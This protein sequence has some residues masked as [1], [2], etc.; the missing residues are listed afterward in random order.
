MILVSFVVLAS[1]NLAAY[2]CVR[3][4]VHLEKLVRMF[5]DKRT[6]IS[7]R[8]DNCLALRQLPELDRLF[9]PLPDGLISV[10]LGEGA[11]PWLR[12]KAAASKNIVYISGATGR[13]VESSLRH[14]LFGREQ[15][16][17]LQAIELL[18]RKFNLHSILPQPTTLESVGA[19]LKE[20][21]KQ[22]ARSFD[23]QLPTLILDHFDG[24]P[25]EERAAIYDFL[26]HAKD[27]K[28]L[29][30]LI[31]IEEEGQL[32][33]ELDRFTS[34]RIDTFTV[35]PSLRPI[36]VRSYLQCRLGQRP[37]KALSRSVYA[38][39]AGEIRLVQQFLTELRKAE[40]RT[41][42]ALDAIVKRQANEFAYS[43]FLLG[44]L[45]FLE[46]RMDKGEF[47]AG[48]QTMFA[49]LDD[50]AMSL[51]ELRLRLG[52]SYNPPPRL[53]QLHFNPETLQQQLKFRTKAHHLFA[54]L[55]LGAKNSLRRLQTYSRLSRLSNRQLV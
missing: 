16:L 2:L 3:R 34:S 51:A 6:V 50:G 12:Q 52:R 7:S 23:K 10:V 22:L 36:E 37:S 24:I 5:A 44:E 17:A 26:K 4:E 9:T 39:T 46:E 8:E 47:L 40:G 54:R 25:A 28:Y 43:G 35:L 13:S 29:N 48:I 11:S 33:S 42:V 1:F 15:N 55:M 27:H 31:V 30:V 32:L 18:Y 49:L 21:R 19:L 14:L 45:G 38:K 20:N 41:A 53:F